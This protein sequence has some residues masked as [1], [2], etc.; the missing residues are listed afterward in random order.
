M[1]ITKIMIMM[2]LLSAH[3]FKAIAQDS[4]SINDKELD[5]LFGKQK[6]RAVT[7]S[8]STI[9]TDQF[10]KNTVSSFGNTLYGKLP[11]LFVKQGAGEPGYDNPTL[12]IRGL[13]TFSGTNTPLVLVDG[14]PRDMNTLSVD[15]VEAVSVLKD[16]A[17]TAM[18]G[19]DGANGVVLVTTKRGVAQKTKVTFRA[20]YGVRTPRVLPQFYGS[21]DYARFYN[22]A[23]KNDG[24]AP[25]YSAE[26]LEGYRTQ[27]DP[28]L[29]PDV[30]WFD[31]TIREYSPTSNYVVDFRGGNKVAKFYVN[32]GYMNNEG[33]YKH[34]EHPTDYSTNANLDR[35]SFRSNLDVNI[36]KNFAVRLDM[37]G[38]LENLNNP[39][40]SATNIFRNLY[41][42]HPNAS[43]VYAFD[44]QLAGSNK[45]Y[46][47]SNSSAVN[48]LGY[49][50][51]KGF[52]KTHRRF[53]QSNI[54]AKYDFSSFIKGLT[55]GVNASFDNYYT[56]QDG[57]KKNFSVVE[58]LSKNADGTY[59]YSDSY[60]Q[61][62]SLTS[63]G[64]GN[65]D[66]NRATNFEL[67]IN[68]ERVFNDVHSFSSV[69]VLHRGEQITDLFTPSKRLFGA[70]RFSY[71]YKNRYFVDLAAQVG[72]SELFL[73][74]KRAGFFPAISTAWVVSSEKFMKSVDVIDYL[75]LKVSTGLVGNQNIGGTRF[76][77]RT[78]YTEYGDGWTAGTSNTNSAR[79]KAEGIIG[80]PNLTWEKSFKTDVGLELV[81]FKDLQLMFTY[82]YEKRFDIRNS[83][84]T[85]IPSFFG[86]GF[87]DESVGRI[88]SYGIEAS[89]GQNKQ[90]R[91]WSFYYN[92]GIA[93]HKNEI[94]YMD[95]ER[96]RWSYLYQ[97][98]KPIGQ[99]FGLVADGYYS[100]QEAADLKVNNTFGTIIPG[101]IKYK[102]INGDNTIDED[103]QVALGSNMT[104]PK[105]ELSL[106]L[107]A[108]FKGVYF[109]ACLQAA[110]GRSVNIR[111]DAAYSA[112]P[113]YYDR[114]I[115][116]YIK[117]PWTPEVAENPTLS[118]MI[119]F[120]SLSIENVGN[121]FQQSSF[122]LKN[123]N[124]LRLRSLELG[125]EFPRTLVSKI[126]MSAA[127]VYFRGMNLLT[128]D[129]LGGSFD[130][131][132]LEG[133]P[134][135]KSIHAGVSITF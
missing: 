15:E 67:Q 86:V 93:T 72:G 30:D 119:D 81:L 49:I 125:Y 19:M 35:F 27:A 96:K 8:I 110:L 20:E 61:N 95:E 41:M 52:T 44:N 118:S 63:W 82:F 120:P 59:N 6:Q 58:V 97:Q 38:R 98:G 102:D 55:V 23:L 117:V 37:S 65:E 47:S 78:L 104:V 116:K 132:I 28:L 14:F 24:K 123:G 129:H 3:T 62:T 99:Y 115:S 91:K 5:V 21:Y 9:G 50:N 51:E 18:Y 17:A 126:R 22:M 42:Y 121:N 122:W 75:K 71:G 33:I 26:Q 79:G 80:N 127:K 87:G 2:M 106:S 1:V 124:F 73:R 85:L 108:H 128:F 111:S 114:N 100:T 16:A 68:Y 112:S 7:S 88:Q 92:L 56:V 133:Y 48:P 66:Q 43:P 57:Y 135:M 103:D 39:A 134:V 34:T 40:N 31:E 74:G 130:P 105:C 70:G 76:G 113:L 46:D 54:K 53:F 32:L 131:E 109:D 89:V 10:S 64:P 60:G 12:Y 13:H 36:T 25:V 29:Y 77:Y 84:N 90:F 69:L 4:L 107:G 94:T 11:G 101:S 83:G 45:Y